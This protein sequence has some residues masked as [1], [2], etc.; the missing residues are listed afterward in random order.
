MKLADKKSAWILF[1]WLLVIV[2]ATCQVAATHW[3]RQLVSTWQVSEH[4][5]LEL[6]QDYGRLLLE[7]SALT[8]HG[9]VERLAKGKLNMKDVKDV[10]V[11]RSSR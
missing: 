9:R 7:Q 4:R 3:H 2:S 1:A 11:I 8:A 6:E 5:R 10:Q